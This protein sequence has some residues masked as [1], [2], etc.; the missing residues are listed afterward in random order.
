MNS[1]FVTYKQLKNRQN[2]YG[3]EC[4]SGNII[5]TSLISR[6]ECLRLHNKKIK[7]KNRKTQK[8]FRKT[9]AFESQM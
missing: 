7:D 2:R 9:I 5:T 1:V 8:Y 3:W 6:E 4:K